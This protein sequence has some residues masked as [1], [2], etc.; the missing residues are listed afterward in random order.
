MA[1]TET[2]GPRPLRADARRNR[3]RV[4][5][6]AKVVVAEHGPDSSLDEIAR[7]AGVGI[8]TLYRHFPTRQALLE[9]VFRDSTEQLADYGRDLLDSD[10]E[11][12]DALRAWLHAQVEHAATHCA[13]AAS[14][15]LT[16]LDRDSDDDGGMPCEELRS[17]GAELLRRAQ[18]AGMIRSDIDVDDVCRMGSAIAIATQEAPGGPVCAERLFTLMMDG[19]GVTTAPAST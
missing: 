13:L 8:G 3:Q 4:L 17:T 2:S 15:I 5:D 18:D 6:A 16:A 1:T 7:R 14:V 11:P 9:A 12:H 10:D 19:L